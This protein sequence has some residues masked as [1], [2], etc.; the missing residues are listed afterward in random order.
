MEMEKP[1]NRKNKVKIPVN[2]QTEI[3]NDVEKTEDLPKDEVE[4]LGS[5]EDLH[6]QVSDLDNLYPSAPAGPILEFEEPKILV[7]FPQALLTMT[8]E[9]QVGLSATAQTDTL[10]PSAPE[11]PEDHVDLMVNASAPSFKVD[12]ASINWNPMPVDVL[13]KIYVNSA[14]PAYSSNVNNFRN[15]VNSANHDNEFY[16]KMREYQFSLLE[17]EEIKKKIVSDCRSIQ[18][19][20]SKYWTLKREPKTVKDYCPDGWSVS[21]TFI[22]ETPV[23]HSELD[24]RFENAFHEVKKT[25]YIDHV[26]L[27]YNSKV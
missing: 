27:S 2:M 15:A 22:D 9:S 20:T 21:H 1:R 17:L 12:L 26:R 3:Q 23:L 24:I 5:W 19:L 14:E 16:R 4:E 10:Q 6:A 7:S 13:E 25:A 18:V 8:V 11:F